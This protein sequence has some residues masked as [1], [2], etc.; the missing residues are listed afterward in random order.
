LPLCGKTRQAIEALLNH[1]YTDTLEN[2]FINAQTQILLLYSM[3]CM[4]GEKETPVF[5]LQVSRQRRG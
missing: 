2:I 4:L 5:Y 1:N 3:D